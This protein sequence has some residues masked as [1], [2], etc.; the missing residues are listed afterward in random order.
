MAGQSAPFGIKVTANTLR[1]MFRK[2]SGESEMCV[3]VIEF[4]GDREN[5]SVTGTGDSLEVSVD[6]T[7]SDCRMSVR[8]AAP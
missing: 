7:G 6:S 1:A 3:E 4:L 5:A 2:Q 8:L